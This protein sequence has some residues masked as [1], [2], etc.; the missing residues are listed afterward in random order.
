MARKTR[1]VCFVT[2]EELKEVNPKNLV[3]LEEF[4]QYYVASDHSDAS[5]LVIRSNLNI[6]FVWLKNH[7]NNKDFKDV[8]KKDILAYQGWLLSNDLS[9]ARV[10]GL[11]SA[12]SSLSIYIEDMLDEEEEWSNFKNLANKIKPPTN[13]PVRVKTILK[14]E[15]IE[16]YLQLLVSRDNF[17]DAQRALALA[18]AW[19]SGSRISELLR[20]KVSFF[21]EE[22]K[23]FNGQL[24]KT[25]FPIKTKGKGRKG[26]PLEKYTLVHKFQP[27]LDHYMK[28]RDLMEIPNEMDELFVSWDKVEK[29]WRPALNSTLESY[30]ETF[31][32][33][34]N[35]DF[36]FH[37]MRHNC[38]TEMLRAGLPESLVVELFGWSSSDLLKVYDDRTKEEKFSQYTLNFTQEAK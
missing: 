6:F 17:R 19:A 15:Q 31:S 25:P 14:D 10:R 4:M 1:K 32:K 3:L 7:R 12:I 13:V 9:P 21:I 8:K 28:H 35:C 16:D 26:K 33:E 22:N 38:C 30:A 24:Y 18:L 5:C 29:K 11:K 2:K 36:Y 20:F 23:C 37:C 34:M 27:Y